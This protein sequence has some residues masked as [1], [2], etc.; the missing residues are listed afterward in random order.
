M[1]CFPGC[2]VAGEAGCAGP[3]VR[4]RF[5][6]RPARRGWRRVSGPVTGLGPVRVVLRHDTNQP[7][8]ARRAAWVRRRTT[9]IFNGIRVEVTASTA[10]SDSWT[11]STPWSTGAPARALD[12]LHATRLSGPGRF[13]HS[14]RGFLVNFAV[15]AGLIIELPVAGNRIGPELG[16]FPADRGGDDGGGAPTRTRARTARSRDR[17]SCGARRRRTAAAQHCRRS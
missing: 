3:A 7:W 4:R 6:R 13:T 1:C 5:P 16:H 10:R 12:G 11:W 2:S 15:P 14:R 9:L 8:A 17:P